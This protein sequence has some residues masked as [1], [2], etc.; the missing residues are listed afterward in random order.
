VLA[1]VFGILGLLVCGIFA[2]F[3]WVYGKRAE[4]AVDASGGA[5]AGRDM[6]TAGKIL[7]I[8][9]SVI[10]ALGLLIGV[11]VLIVLIAGSAASA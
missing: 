5:Y 2:P 3:A 8:V 6:A 10:L 1:L 4:E 11:V 7:G 9:G